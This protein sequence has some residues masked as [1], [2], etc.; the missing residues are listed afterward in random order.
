M[1][2]FFN[3][4]QLFLRR[5]FNINQFYGSVITDDEI[6]LVTEYM[7]VSRRYRRCFCAA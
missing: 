4:P 6:M 5:D 3:L 7:E 1:S 2:M